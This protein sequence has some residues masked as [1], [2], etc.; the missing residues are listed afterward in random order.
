[1]ITTDGY[2]E[3]CSVVAR[4]EEMLHVT[5]KGGRRGKQLLY[6][7]KGNERLL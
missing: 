3:N 5:G 2:I 1:M 6:G 7:R 4:I